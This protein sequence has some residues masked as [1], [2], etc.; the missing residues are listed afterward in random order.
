M[1]TSPFEAARH[2]FTLGYLL[3]DRE[4]D[5]GESGAHATNDVL[6]AI[7]SGALTGQGHLLD[8]V[9]PGK[10]CCGIDVSP[11]DDFV[12]EAANDGGVLVGHTDSPCGVCLHYRDW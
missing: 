10:L 11:G 7:Q 2:L 1:R 12:N 4:D 8:D 9:F 6:Q 5:V 3:L